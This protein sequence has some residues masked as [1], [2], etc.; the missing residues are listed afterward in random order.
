MITGLNLP[1]SDCKTTIKNGKKYIFD[2]LRKQFV[3]LTPEELVR[4][5]FINFLIEQKKFPEGLL[6]NEVCIEL[7]N[8]KKRCDTVLYDKSLNPIL[9][10]EFKAPSIPITQNTFDQI[11]RY[12]MILHVP[13]LI[14]S[15]GMEHYCCSVNFE[16]NTYEF[17]KE[18]PDY[19]LL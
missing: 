11:I 7:A 17:E 4:Q 1:A 5:Q 14:I 15:N 19:H 9:L 16:T 13:W 3:R 8:T 2:R 6:A 12:N 10:I 18:I